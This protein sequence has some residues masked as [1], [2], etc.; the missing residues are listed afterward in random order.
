MIMPCGSRD[1]LLPFRLLANS[2]IRL[3]VIVFTLV[4]ASFTNIY[5]TQPV[6][7]VLQYEFIVDQVL[8]SFTVS[9]VILGIALANP[10]FCL[11]QVGKRHAAGRGN[12]PALSG[13]G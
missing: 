5:L 13:N 2:H 1:P 10:P 6:L 4:T 11:H 8:I 12:R 9:A 3:Q 7:P